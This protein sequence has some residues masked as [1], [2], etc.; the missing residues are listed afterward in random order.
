MTNLL[1]VNAQ[2]PAYRAATRTGRSRPIEWNCS[3]VGDL[4]DAR[5]L[6]EY[7]TVLAEA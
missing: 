6:E 1:S 5:D 2:E 4:K 7:T 3:V